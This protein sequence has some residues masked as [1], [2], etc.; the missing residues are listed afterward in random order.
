MDEGL[1]EF[2]AIKLVVAVRVVHLKVME[3]QLLFRH[4]AGVDRDVHVLF[5]VPERENFIMIG[6]ANGDLS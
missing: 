6:H 5:H 3:L 1:N 4:V 2:T